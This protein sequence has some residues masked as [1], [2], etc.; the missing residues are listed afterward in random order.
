MLVKIDAVDLIIKL[1]KKKKSNDQLRNE[2]YLFAIA[3]LF[4]GNIN[5]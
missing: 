4:G 5:A 3:L 1:L 2:L